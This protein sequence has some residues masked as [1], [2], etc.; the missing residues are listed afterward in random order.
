LQKKALSR[1]KGKGPLV[2]SLI[3]RFSKELLQHSLITST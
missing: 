3:E 2:R 1:L